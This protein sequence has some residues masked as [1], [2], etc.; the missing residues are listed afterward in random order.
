TSKK[1][2]PPQW[3]AGIVA[4]FVNTLGMFQSVLRWVLLPLMILGAILAFRLDWRVTALIMTIVFYYL[5]VGSLMHTHIRY[6]LPMHA[7]LTIFAGLALW[8]IKEL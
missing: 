2:L 1:C 6:G 4:F 8:R 5:V 7:L 3:Q